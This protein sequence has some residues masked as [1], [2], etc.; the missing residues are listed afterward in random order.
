MVG[1]KGR[2]ARCICTAA[3]SI[4]SQYPRAPGFRIL[5]PMFLRKLFSH[6]GRRSIF[7]SAG[8]YLRR[9][10]KGIQSVHGMRVF[11]GLRMILLTHA[12]PR[13]GSV[14][15]RR[16]AI[17]YVDG[18]RAFQRIDQLLRS[19]RFAIAIHM[20]IWVDDMTGRGI[21]ERLV[22][23][24]DRGVQVRITKD[25]AGDL[26]ELDRDF[27]TTKSETSSIWHRFWSHPRIVVDTASERNHAK[28]FVVDDETIL[29]GGMNIANAYRF[30]WHDFLV[31]LR[32]KRFVDEYLSGHRT[33]SGHERVR[34]VVNGP[35]GREV[36]QALTHLLKS[37][38][39]EIILEHAYFS[40]PEILHTL[41]DASRRGVHVRIILPGESDVFQNANA[42]SIAQLLQSGNPARIQIFRYPVM[43]HG[44]LVL[45]DRQRAF[46]GSANMM[47]T[48]L[49]AM[50]EVNVLLSGRHTAI[51]RSIR[52][53]VREDL[54]RSAPIMSP[55]RLRWLTRALAALGL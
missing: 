37:A 12:R 24:A 10:R 33:S 29:L 50:G 34:L 40:D 11:Y 53:T 44:K 52:D 35:H 48:S 54:I 4:L 31:E 55:P 8:A 2:I 1:R 9:Q 39:R 3:R 7:R 30:R 51:L 28:V 47:T 36:R 23:A 6:R 19:A 41:A 21:A 38:K 42:V 32:G 22:E 20:F 27:V 25:T 26:F 49:D 14:A 43:L 15:R 5:V 18:E 16:E 17:L 45:V 46:I 13:I